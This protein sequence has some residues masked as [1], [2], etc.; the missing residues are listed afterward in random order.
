M[1][2]EDKADL[3]LFEDE[4]KIKEKIF[5]AIKDPKTDKKL[6]AMLEN[7]RDNDF[8]YPPVIRMAMIRAKTVDEPELREVLEF[9]L[10]PLAEEQREKEHLEKEQLEKEQLEK[11]HLEKEQLEK[12]QLEKEQLE[13]EHLEKEQR[14]KEQLKKELLDSKDEVLDR[15]ICCAGIY[16]PIS[17]YPDEHKN[18][19]LSKQLYQNKR[20]KHDPELTEE[21]KA[22]ICN[23]MCNKLEKV[24]SLDK[25]EIIVPVP[26]FTNPERP[27]PRCAPPLAVGLAAMICKKRNRKN[28]NSY[29]DILVKKYQQKTG[30]DRDARRKDAEKNFDIAEYIKTAENSRIKDQTVLLI[31]DVRTSGA[32]SEVC[33][34]L[35]A[36]FKPKQ[37]I[38]LCA[39]QTQ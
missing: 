29:N 15:K 12:E 14:E 22:E 1:N 27:E 32:T 18:H 16:W 25:I 11:E 30:N 5:A 28:C 24:V 2:M 9:Q 7:I 20:W 19:P 21:Q 10:L 6:K 39:A 4:A 33:A 38:I 31:D 26:N 17:R 35:L 13:K 34:K 3:W 23:L 37:V 8:T 36:Y